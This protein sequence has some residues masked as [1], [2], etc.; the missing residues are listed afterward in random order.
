MS[1]ERYELQTSKNG[2]HTFKFIPNNGGTEIHHTV[3]IGGISAGATPGTP[4]TTGT[5]TKVPKT[6]P[7]ENMIVITLITLGLY[8][9]Y[10][11]YFKKA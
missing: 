1:D 9:G 6:G 11:K 7:A 4:A 5:I 2:E 10:K 8:F 3:T